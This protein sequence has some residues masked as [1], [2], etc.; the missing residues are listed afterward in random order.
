MKNMN[1]VIVAVM[2]STLLFFGC[3]S[4]GQYQV[5]T[6]PTGNNQTQN[7]NSNEQGGRIIISIRDAAAN[8][9]SVSSVKVTIDSVSVHSA[10][11]GWVTVANSP[12]TYDLLALKA[13][14]ANAIVVDNT[15][16]QDTYDQIKLEISNVMVTDRN[17]THQARVPSS[18]LLI[19][20]QVRVNNGMTS[21]ISLD[22][23]ADESLHTTNRGEYVIAPVIEIE[24]RENTQVE[25]NSGLVSYSGGS[26]SSKRVGTDIDGRVDVGVGVSANEI[27][28]IQNNIIRIG[29]RSSSSSNTSVVV[30]NTAGSGT[31]DVGSSI[32]IR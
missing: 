31:V 3:T 4:S 5:N 22:F 20:N 19:N 12:Q 13:Q 7:N 21:S 29:S 25:V 23:I 11:R 28:E 14:S 32:V 26:V 6:S 30:N 9:N 24:N 17:G 8:M 2:L 16:D 27:L 1:L 18:Q 15:V 10:S